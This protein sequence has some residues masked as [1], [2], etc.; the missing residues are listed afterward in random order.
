[1]KKLLICLILG[2]LF[3]SF[4]SSKSS[5]RYEMPLKVNYNQLRPEVKAEIEC[6]TNNIFF[7]AAHE[8]RKGKEAVA[9]VT[10]N[11]VNSGLYPQSICGVV[12]QKTTGVCQF[13]WYCQEKENR[14]SYSKNLT[15]AQEVLYNEIRDLAIY[16][17]ANYEKLTDPTK[18]A[19]FYHADYVRPKWRN[20]VYS[21]TI[22]RHIFYVRKDTI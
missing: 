10:L 9:F 22:G 14:L 13:S 1:M 16:V 21:T 4:S 11:R 8:P 17:Y 15:R 5:T 12:K 3:I 19:L 18:G 20:V 6:L 7:E 2:T